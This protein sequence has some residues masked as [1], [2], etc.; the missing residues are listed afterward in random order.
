MPISLRPKHLSRYRDLA[1]LLA[2]HGRADIV[3]SAGLEEALLDED[4]ADTDRAGAAAAEDLAQDLEQLGPTYVKLGQLLSTRADLLPDAYLDAL[5]RLQDR[6]EPFPFADVERIVQDELGVRIG[7]AFT[8]FEPAPLAAASLGQVHRATLRDGRPVAVKVQRPGIRERV[9]D[10]LDALAE[11]ARFLDSHTEQGRRY[12]FADILHEFRTSLFR[13]LDY[14]QEAANLTTLAG[15]LRDFERILIPEPI[16]DYTTSR[17]LTMEYVRGRKITGISP[18]A[19]LEVDGE[20]LGDDLFRAYLKQVLVDGLFH[21]DPHPGNVFLTDDHRLALID[22]GMIGH[23]TPQMQEK[24]MKLLLA[25]ADGEGEDAARLA[26]EMGEKLDGFDERKFVRRVAEIVTTQRDATLHEIDVGR[27]FLEITRASGE[28]GVR[29]PPELTM[30][31]KTL[32]NLDQVAR[33][34]SPEFNHAEAIR[35][36]AVEIL[37]RR[38][39]RSASPGNL[40]SAALEMNEFVQRLPGRLNRALDR[41][42]ENQLE[43][44]VNAIN[45]EELI[46]GLQKIANRIT[47]GLVLAALIVG[48]AMLM[49]VQTP[50][51]ILGYPGFAMILFLAAAIGG[52]ALVYNILT[53]DRTP[54][55][56][57]K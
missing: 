6:V 18:L 15:N 10:D 7:K 51:T 1:R 46:S 17:V 32:L 42:A 13:E 44:R 38:M 12:G 26:I 34:L 31:G 43:L 28:H 36:H 39:L 45:E 30:L 16:S 14:R 27:V 5:T 50:W 8:A 37:R 21:A 57:R 20:Q 40:F 56:P 23:V 35:R 11:L 54:R 24:L 33:T 9:R 52:V 41:V 4:R 47:M 22:L 3:A 19:R 53:H 2:R 49:Q 55:T 25:V 29:Q 48:A